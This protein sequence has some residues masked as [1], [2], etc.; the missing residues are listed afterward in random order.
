MSLFNP[1]PWAPEPCRD[2]RSRWPRGRV[3]SPTALAVSLFAR[4]MNV[5][6]GSGRRM[7]TLE[8]PLMPPLWAIRLCPPKSAGAGSPMFQP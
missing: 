4:T 7:M 8:K 1:S 2:A 5:M 3:R 6:F